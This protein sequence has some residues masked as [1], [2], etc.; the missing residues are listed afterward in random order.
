MGP[1][2]QMNIALLA[3]SS[4]LVTACQDGKFTAFFFSFF[5]NFISSLIYFILFFIAF[6]LEITIVYFCALTST[7]CKRKMTLSSSRRLGCKDA[8]MSERL[9]M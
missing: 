1:L 6:V 3:L 8:L 5:L 9:S 4:S 7:S 2:L